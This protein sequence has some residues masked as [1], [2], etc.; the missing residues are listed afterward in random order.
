M[1]AYG[2]GRCAL[3]AFLILLAL[4]AG[5][6]SAEPG[7]LVPQLYLPL[8]VG[9][10]QLTTTPEPTPE[11]TPRPTPVPGS[12]DDG[13]W[14][15]VETW[16][17]QL[18]GYHNGGLDEIAASAFDLAV[19][20]LARDGYTD[21][22][23]RDEISALQ[24]EGKVVLAYFE[25]GA[26]ENY[27]PEWPDV[28]DDLKLGTV[29]GWPGERYVKYWD[30]RWW[31]VVKGRVDQ[32][33]AAGFDGAYLDMIVTYEEIPANS[34]GTNRTDLARKMVALIERLSIYAKQVNADFKVVPQN[35]PELHV[36]DG[37]LDAID[38]L[39]M[40]ELYVLAMDRRCTAGWCYE[41]RDNA[42][43]VAAAGKLVLTVDYANQQDNID[44]A[45]QQSFAAGFVPYVS[46][47]SLNIVRFNL[48][49]PP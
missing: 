23:T 13:R 37:Y 26:I 41:N 36:H 46:V 29:S 22:F 49:W 25:I 9:C 10:R 40:E 1:P 20:D 44:F 33:L 15:N 4:S 43:D 14:G 35:S 39:G 17:Y 31:P 2:T 5:P 38:G 28:P 3:V 32:A 30:E 48:G 21:Y 12:G 7:D 27:R 6:T 11:P 24:Q 19:V 34:A 8:I 42:A 47:R 18:S 16:V 45:Y